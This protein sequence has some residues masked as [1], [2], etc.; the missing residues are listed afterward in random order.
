[1]VF[2]CAFVLMC[3]RPV[4]TLCVWAHP[5]LI[6]RKQ[7]PVYPPLLLPHFGNR[8][9]TLLLTR[10]EGINTLGQVTAAGDP[11]WQQRC[12]PL[13]SSQAGRQ[14]GAASGRERLAQGLAWAACVGSNAQS[15]SPGPGHS[16]VSWAW[17]KKTAREER[18][19][20]RERGIQWG[21]ELSHL[22]PQ[23]FLSSCLNW[24][25]KCTCHCV[26]LGR[27]VLALDGGGGVRGG[28]V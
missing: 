3:A 2:I 14:A 17:A 23:L 18:R 1:M 22:L 26:I 13:Q 6:E 27:L 24:Q 12:P 20:P 11:P 25:N 8:A 7:L 19:E 21:E 4:P 16:P 9:V 28:R 5:R 15:H 10:S